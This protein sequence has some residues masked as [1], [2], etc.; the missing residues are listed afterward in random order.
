[1]P[2]AKSGEI[3]VWRN[4][5]RFIRR[6]GLKALYGPPSSFKTSLMLT[7][8][9][10]QGGEAAYIG[11]GKHVFCRYSGR[12]VDVFH[13]VSFRDAVSI[14]LDLAAEGQRGWKVIVY[15]GFGSEYMPLYCGMRER[16]VMQAALFVVSILRFIATKISASVLVVTTETHRGRPLFYNVLGKRVDFFVRTSLAEGF[17]KASVLTPQL[18]EEHAYLIPLDSIRKHEEVC[19]GEPP[20][21]IGFSGSLH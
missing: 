6:P 2:P 13:A 9:E 18:L 15:D 20:H 17:V 8:L 21:Q 5:L 7:C 14:L 4:F 11:L 12:G 3:G 16:S 19:T 1:M 10:A